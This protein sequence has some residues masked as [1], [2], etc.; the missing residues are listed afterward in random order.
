MMKI[1]L[2][3]TDGSPH[4]EKAVEVGAALAKKFGSRVIVLHVLMRSASF[5][6]I[7]KAFKAQGLP[8]SVLDELTRPMPLAYG[9]DLGASP[10]DPVV[11]LIE[12]GTLGQRILDRA[13]AFLTKE[14]IAD[15]R[16]FMEDGDPAKTILE[17]ANRESADTIVMGHRGLGALQEVI[18]GG[19]STKVGHLAPCTVITVK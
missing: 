5:D 11:P 15:V 3:A 19:V 13:K 16:T 9:F 1:I 12:L 8:T 7:H 17:I 6:A 4:A 2:I 10:I 18:V 14:G